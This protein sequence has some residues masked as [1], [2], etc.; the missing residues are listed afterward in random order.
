LLPPT[1]SHIFSRRNIEE[2][3]KRQPTDVWLRQLAN[4]IFTVFSYGKI[5][6]SDT[7]KTGEP[8]ET[9]WCY[10]HFPLEGAMPIPD[11][12]HPEY[13]YYE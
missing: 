2:L 1:A 8:H 3:D 10:V 13:N 7:L 11:A 4:G 6:Y 12:F 5:I 9:G